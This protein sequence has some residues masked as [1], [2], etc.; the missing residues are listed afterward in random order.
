MDR[1]KLLR[2][3]GG[4]FVAAIVLGLGANYMAG[5]TVGD[6]FDMVTPNAKV[7][8]ERANEIFIDNRADL[9]AGYQKG[10]S[11]IAAAYSDWQAASTA[12]AKTGDIHSGRYMM[13]YLNAVGYDDYIEYSSTG[14]EMPI[15]TQIAKETFMLKGSGKF[16]PSPLFTMEK[17]GLEAAPETGGWVYGRVNAHG[18]AMPTGQAFC[19]SCHEAFA[20]QDSLGYPARDVR[21]G[22]T[23][24]EPGAQLVQFATGDIARGEKV[25]Q[26]CASCH[27]I[28]E[29]ASNAFG[30]VL[31]D[32]VG[33]KAGSFAGYNYSPGLKA[34]GEDGLVWTEQKLFEW[35]ADPTGFLRRNR[36][37]DSLSSKMPVGFDDEQTR[38]DVIAFL[39]AQGGGGGGSA[40][41]E[42]THGDT[43][44]MRP[45]G[46]ISV[47]PDEYDDLPRKRLELVTPP[48][49]P[50]H[51]QK[52]DGPPAIIEVELVVEEKSWTLDNQGTQIVALT[53][54]GSIPAPMIIVHQGD[55]V[56]LTLKNPSTNT[57]VHNID[58]HA[59]TGA[60]G[61]AA[62]TTIS[63][64]EETVLRFEATKAGAFLYH[65]AP[66]GSMTPY[67]VTHGMT[68]SIMVL[69]RE[70]LTDGAGNELSYDKLYFVG[71]NDFYVPRDEDGNFKSY[72]SA[73]EDY[74]DW[75]DAMHTLTPSHV[76]FNGRVGALTGEGAMTADVGET[77]MFVHMQG[78]RDTRPHLIGGHGDYVWEEGA[79]GNPPMRDLETWFV[80]GGS[81]GA[82]LYTFKQPGVYAYLNHNLIEAVE[83]GA[84]G[85]VVVGGEWDDRLMRQSYLGPIRDE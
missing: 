81:V 56:E 44:S 67:H 75:I 62:L 12:P 70:G 9:V 45:E 3:G 63:P 24:E 59:A 42:L 58:L 76:V 52:A 32:V 35:L 37:D 53:Y 38:N 57:M 60:L 39:A 7:S 84:A 71:E 61:G 82:A 28:G 27:N 34:A 36:G 83:F 33:R 29:G 21:I 15:G 16:R 54:N 66:E 18:R 49:A 25:F 1:K 50:E 11:E 68:G 80:R 6:L 77:V 47:E 4:G 48:F 74:A 14:A 55:F 72:T 40:S 10:S 17:V 65:C 41:P 79:F 2:F 73:G 22:Y 64:G 8:A 46:A 51:T 31:T 69:P 85:H 19:H 13:T 5:Q 23:P 78:N 20:G 43:P 30:P 26:T